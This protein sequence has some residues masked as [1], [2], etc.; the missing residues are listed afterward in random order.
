MS[1]V[2]G[3]SPKGST[4]FGK[5]GCLRKIAYFCTGRITTN[6]KINISTRRFCMYLSSPLS[7]ETQDQI[8]C[9]SLNLV[10][11]DT[12]MPPLGLILV[13]YKI[14]SAIPTLTF[15]SH[16]SRTAPDLHKDLC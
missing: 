16:L 13:G 9:D 2:N 5:Q 10:E 1:D 14:T 11:S 3:R 15:N 7:L 6:H 12:L 8:A 4:K